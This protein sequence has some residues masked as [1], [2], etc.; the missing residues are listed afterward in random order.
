MYS[1][2]YIIKYIIN[3]IKSNLYALSTQNQ[4]KIILYKNAI[5]DINTIKEPDNFKEA[6]NLNYKKYWTEAMQKELNTLKENKTWQIISNN[7]I[8]NMKPLTRW[9]Y[10]IKNK[11]NYIK[12]KARFVAKY[13]EQLLE[14]DYIDFY[15]FIIK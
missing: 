7:N 6:I 12:F 1:V 9:I 8:N 15:A 10:K 4:D 2:S 14:L 11:F 5:S 3:N 13:F